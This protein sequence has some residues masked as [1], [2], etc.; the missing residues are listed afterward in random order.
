VLHKFSSGV[1]KRYVRQDSFHAWHATIHFQWVF[2]RRSADLWILM[3]LKIQTSRAKRVLKQPN[4][5]NSLENYGKKIPVLCTSQKT[6]IH[7]VGI[8]AARI[9]TTCFWR[10]QSQKERL[11]LTLQCIAVW[12]SVLQCLVVCCSVLQ[13]VAVCCSVLQCAAVCCSVLKWIF[14]AP[15][16]SERGVVSHTATHCSVLQ[17]LYVVSTQSKGSGSFLLATRKNIQI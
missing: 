4:S 5:P 13:C 7:N 2:T 3:V 16:K 6:H 12:C 10:G 11:F 15:T 9:D 17:C 14:L 1:W 8:F